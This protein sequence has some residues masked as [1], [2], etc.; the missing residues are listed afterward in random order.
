M[1]QKKLFTWALLTFIGASLALTAYRAAKDS[2]EPKPTQQASPVADAA[3]IPTPAAPISPKT[4]APK[5]KAAGK[6]TAPA[7]K[8]AGQI[9]AYYFHGFARCQTCR[10]LETYTQEAI[11]T[12]FGPEIKSGRIKWQVFN[13]EEPE[14][15]HFIQD[16][17]LNNKSVILAIT[18][19]G[20][21]KD[22]KNLSQIWELVGDKEQFLKYVQGEVRS[23]QTKL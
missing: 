15:K 14:N 8:A 7:A 2:R 16:F 21:V 5:P 23:Y 11:E 13:V 3:Q 6:T 4:T 18:Q 9:L 17:Q 12:G 20:A 1:T 19:G 22:W 10:K